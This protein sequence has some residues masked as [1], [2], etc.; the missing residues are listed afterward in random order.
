MHRLFILFILIPLNAIFWLIASVLQ[1]IGT[2]ILGA[3]ALCA[4]ALVGLFHLISTR[5]E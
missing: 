4:A 3:F 2:L 5:K 1:V